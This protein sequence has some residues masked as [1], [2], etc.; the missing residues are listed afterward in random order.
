M[1]VDETGETSLEYICDT[2]PTMD[3][4]RGTYVLCG[5]ARGERGMDA[6]HTLRIGESEDD[7]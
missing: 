6:G 7:G 1:S 2:R 3:D 4:D 5:D